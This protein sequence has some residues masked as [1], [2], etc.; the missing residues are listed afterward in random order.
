M[1]S[2]CFLSD[3]SM[4]SDFTICWIEY[5]L[6]WT[7][8][9][10][11]R[12]FNC[13]FFSAMTGACRKKSPSISKRVFNLFK[14]IVCF[15]SPLFS[16]DSLQRSFRRKNLKNLRWFSS[17]ILRAPR[18]FANGNVRWALGQKPPGAPQPVC[19]LSDL[20]LAQLGDSDAPVFA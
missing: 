4:K 2:E 8:R 1:K 5:A 7:K 20:F 9:N 19:S 17:G 10:F 12:S 6:P 11:S 13:S 3:A 16:V 14:V 18:A 15:S